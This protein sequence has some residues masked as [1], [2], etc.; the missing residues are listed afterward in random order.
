MGKPAKHMQLLIHEHFQHLAEFVPCSRLFTPPKLLQEYITRNERSWR[1]FLPPPTKSNCGN[2]VAPCPLAPHPWAPAL[3]GGNG[4]S[5]LALIF[6]SSCHCLASMNERK[7]DM[8]TEVVAMPMTPRNVTF[9]G[10]L[11]QHTHTDTHRVLNI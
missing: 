9:Y 4:E 3:S 2:R 11:P 6:H 7:H 10:I 5:S 1:P 8:G